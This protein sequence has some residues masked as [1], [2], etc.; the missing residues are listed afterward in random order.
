MKT[1]LELLTKVK[2]Q[3][4]ARGDRTG[5]GTLSVFTHTFEHDMRTGFPLPTTKKMHLRGIFEEL[6]AIVR[7]ELHMESL[8]AEEVKIWDPWRVQEAVKSKRQLANYERIDWMRQN[9]PE[10][11]DKWEKLSIQIKPE[12]QGHDWLDKHGV[13]RSV[14]V[15]TTKVGDLN[16]PY[17][18]GWRAF[19]TA[20]GPVDQFAYAMDLLRNNPES[21][22]ILVSAWNPGWMPE[23]TREVELSNEEMWDHL[24]THSPDLYA[25]FWSR[26]DDHGKTT[27]CQEFLASHG[28]PRTKTVKVTPQENVINGKPCLTPC[29]WAF[30]FYTEEMTVSERMA[31]VE[32]GTEL[33]TKLTALNNALP[34]ATAT[35]EKSEAA[36]H[37]LLTEHDVPTRYL[38]LKWH[39]RSCDVILGI[40]YNIASYALLLMMVAEQ[41]GMVPY[42]LVG[43]LTNVH[44]YNNLMHVADKQLPREPYPLPTVQFKRKPGRIEDYRWQDVELVGYQSHPAIKG[45]PSI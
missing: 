19:Q 15:V 30:E 27:D 20:N 40:P 1:Y 13:P 4:R 45:K 42:M 7:G 12:A 38:S 37:A 44:I 3:G 25:V 9:S 28:V 32:V 18:P 34:L 14:D 5:T 33:H 10:L 6:M 43:D 39:Q 35:V 22:R 41:V 16:A 8:V 36:I 17:G 11:L 24:K 31:F 26:L 29:H 21:R 2:E 23:E